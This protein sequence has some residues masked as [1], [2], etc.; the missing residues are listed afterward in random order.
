MSKHLG[1]K[2][3][4]YAWGTLTPQDQAQAE[5]HLRECAA[6]RAELAQHQ[7]LVRKIATAVPTMLPAEPAS[8]RSGWANVAARIPQL[9]PVSTPRR[10]GL[11]GLAAVGLAMS[12]AAVLLVAVITQ[13][14]LY[15]P[16]LMATAL[17]ATQSATPAAS[18][19]YTPERCTPVATPMSWM[20]IAPPQPP[21]PL[22]MAA[23]AKP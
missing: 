5:V 10:Q 21:L 20:Y 7:A 9:R 23:T 4:D 14:W 15:Q 17:S 12:T 3:I 1:D 2:L 19:T 18:A 13:V 11:P 16:P 22:P 8:V 6:C